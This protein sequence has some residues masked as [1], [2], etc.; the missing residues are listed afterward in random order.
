MKKLQLALVSAFILGLLIGFLAGHQLGAGELGVP[1]A[2]IFGVLLGV[3]L[4][5][6]ASW[7][8]IEVV[9]RLSGDRKDGD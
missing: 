3:V 5:I 2:L 1:G 4:V 7:I 9:E 8:G 6:A